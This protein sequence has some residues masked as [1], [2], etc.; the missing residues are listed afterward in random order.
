VPAYRNGRQPYGAWTARRLA[1]TRQWRD[2]GSRTGNFNQDVGFAV[3]NRRNRRHIAHRVGAQGII[4]NRD[5]GMVYRAFGYPATSPY[6]GERLVYCRGRGRPD[7]YDPRSTAQGIACNMTPG[8]SGG[9]WLIRFD[10]DTGRGLV[11]SVTSY[12]YRGVPRVFGPYFGRPVQRVYASLQPTARDGSY[13][14]VQE[15]GR[16]FRVVDGGLKRIRSWRSVGGVK[17]H[18][19]V[20]A[21]Y[22]R[23]FR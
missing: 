17:K 20:T 10:R 19:D 11:N 22:L 2:R 4:F 12:L 7:R 23:R 6:N 8:A 13:L 1:T 15:D 21:I 3:L 5:R 9:P 16:I 18:Y 14:R